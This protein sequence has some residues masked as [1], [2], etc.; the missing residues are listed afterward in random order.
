MNDFRRNRQTRPDVS[1]AKSYS[2]THK[3]RSCAGETTFNYCMSNHEPI[4]HCTLFT[5]KYTVYHSLLIPKLNK[6]VQ[7]WQKKIPL[8]DTDKQH[9]NKTL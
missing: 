5:P 4:L 3:P 1:M 9:T 7:R 6:F 8:H 2:K